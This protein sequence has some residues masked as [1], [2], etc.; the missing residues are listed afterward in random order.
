MGD[1]DISPTAERLTVMSEKIREKEA[2]TSIVYFRHG[3][4]DFSEERFYSRKEDPSL[5]IEGKAQA[6]R[7]GRWV[8]GS[9]IEVLYSSPLKRTMET[10]VYI[11]EGLKLK[12]IARSG[13][14]ER[15]MGQWEGM[16]PG[17]VKERYPELFERWKS[18]LLGFVPPGGESWREFGDRVVKTLHQIK[19]AH[20]NQR[21]AVVTHVG[22]IRVLVSRAMEMAD[23][24]HKRIVL[25]YGSATRI[26]Y[27]KKWGNLC[28]LGVI[29]FEQ[30]P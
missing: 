28:Y 9:G 10:A 13:L 7:L 26:D 8:K 14:E 24:N 29:P 5:S 3:K 12:L 20:P 19:E 22:P 16:T 27:T 25:G 1:L 17:E 30:Q 15:E 11:S 21:I 18:D 6:E 23:E 4:T 2:S